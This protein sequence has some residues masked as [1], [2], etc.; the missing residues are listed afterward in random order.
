MT[1]IAL[2]AD[3]HGNMIA[4]D[5]VLADIATFNVDRI[6]VAGDV[7]NWGPHNGE[8]I[9]RIVSEGCAVIR[10]NQEFYV[11][12]Q[13]TRRAPPAW[14]TYTV[15]RWT[16]QQ[17]GS[18]WLNVIATWPDSLTLRFPDAPNVR[19]VHGSP[20]SHFEAIFPSMSDTEIGDILA[21]VDEETVV[22]A[23]T[24]LPL[25]RQAGKWHVLNPGSVGMPL[26]GVMES[27]YLILDGDWSGWR[28]T[29]RRVPFDVTPIL[30]DF[31][32]LGFAETCGATGMLVVE[33]FRTAR[34]QVLPFIVWSRQF[35]DEAQDVLLARFRAEHVD[36]WSYIH[37]DYH[38]NL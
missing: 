20:N 14:N 9:E 31:E 13:D 28:G 16:R 11:L 4:L 19:V 29:L 18:Q 15:A 5:A 10:G 21:G 37:P 36:P 33:E 24:H 30:R 2:I 8:V 22:A 6:A 38:I 26:N 25:D 23:H 35:P 27:T 1:R 17:L 7:V 32:R 34:L 12:D 3:I